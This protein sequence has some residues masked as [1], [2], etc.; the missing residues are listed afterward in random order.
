MAV[1]ASAMSLR[2]I[3]I[4]AVH[5]RTCTLANVHATI[6]NCYPVNQ[7]SSYIF[8]STNNEILSCSA[9]ECKSMAS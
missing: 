4:A 7:T 9:T 1:L 5:S 6:K 8:L 3:A 2:C